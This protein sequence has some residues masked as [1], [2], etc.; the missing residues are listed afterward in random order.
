MEASGGVFV[1]NILFYDERLRSA[2]VGS[3][4]DTWDIAKNIYPIN[5]FLRK[6]LHE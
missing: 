5:V 1:Q 2:V 3:G 4:K 6:N